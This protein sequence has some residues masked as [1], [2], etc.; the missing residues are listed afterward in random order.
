MVHASSFKNSFTHAGLEVQPH[1]LSITAWPLPV[2]RVIC[3]CHFYRR[4]WPA[5]QVIIIG[6]VTDLFLRDYSINLCKKRK[7][8][9]SRLAGLA[10][11]LSLM[12][13]WDRPLSINHYSEQSLKMCGYSGPNQL[14]QA[15]SHQQLGL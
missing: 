2:R 10:H 8:N 4:H 11:S 6:A 5:R 3:W 12:L 9:S 15:L 1:H 13:A 14:R 7:G